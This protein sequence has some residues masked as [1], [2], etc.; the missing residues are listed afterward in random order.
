[1][2]APLPRRLVIG[3]LAYTVARDQ[4]AIDR[5]SLEQGGELAGY[6][7]DCDQTILLAEKLGPDTEAETLLHEVL[8]QC[9]ATAGIRLDE[10][11]AAGVKELEERAVRSLAGALLGTLRRNPK[12]VAYLVGD[13]RAPRRKGA[14][15]T[16]RKEGDHDGRSR[17]RTEGPGPSSPPQ[18]G[19]DPAD[20]P[21]VPTG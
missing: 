2:S 12:L 18:Q 21:G 5:K 13:A 10:D 1:V 9:L 6:S 4:R 8:H 11:A 16:R 19:H 17:P 15:A 3:H 20:G 14:D 7:W